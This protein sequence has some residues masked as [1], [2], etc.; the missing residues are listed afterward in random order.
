M[1]LFGWFLWVWVCSISCLFALMEW[2]C[3]LIEWFIVV[4][5]FGVG[6]CLPSCCV[7]G[8]FD[9]LFRVLFSDD[10]MVVHLFYSLVF[11][12]YYFVLLYAGG[13]LLFACAL[14]G[15]V[16]VFGVYLAFVGMFIV[17]WVYAILGCLM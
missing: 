2:A 15:V 13:L 16:G 12:Y 14:L 11:I 8:L 4:D 1:L 7:C 3:C 10:L 9:C 5:S 6:L 17:F